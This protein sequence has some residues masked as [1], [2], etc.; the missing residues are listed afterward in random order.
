M[1]PKII[2]TE[3]AAYKLEDI[4]YYFDM[5]ERVLVEQGSGLRRIPKL[6]MSAIV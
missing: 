4:H 5:C 3:R 1:M 2:P 6:C